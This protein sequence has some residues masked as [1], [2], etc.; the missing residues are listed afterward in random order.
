[1]NTVSDLGLTIVALRTALGWSQEALAAAA[2]I[3]V[4]TIQRIES[5]QAGAV[6]AVAAIAR[7]FGLQDVQAIKD[8]RVALDRLSR[9]M[10]IPAVRTGKD[11]VRLVNGAHGHIVDVPA[12][13]DAIR[14]AAEVV[15][16][17]A[18][19]WND[20]GLDEPAMVFEAERGLN[21]NLQ[22]LEQA[23]GRLFCFRR[24]YES[25]FKDPKGKPIIM[26]TV[27]FVVHAE[28]H[29][30]IQ[31]DDTG[32]DVLLTLRDKSDNVQVRV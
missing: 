19:D 24:P 11:L 32:R 30:A 2:N 27:V 25:D 4:R 12:T 5:G 6:E 15:I 29:P 21:D 3:N 28:K 20:I 17:N 22:A 31:R 23:G 1:M 9:V 26:D 8:L 14:E 16:Q 10:P 13:E 7:A 18:I